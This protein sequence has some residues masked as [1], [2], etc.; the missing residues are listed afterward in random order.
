M[1]KI[2]FMKYLSPVRLK[3]VPKLKVLKL[4]PK[5]KVLRIS[6]GDLRFNVKNIFYE[7]FTN[8]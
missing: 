3:L 4:V 7:I 6:Y 2:I 8:S 1:S 5:L